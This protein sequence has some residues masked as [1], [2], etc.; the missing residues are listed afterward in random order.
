MVNGPHG[1]WFRKIQ[2]YICQQFRTQKVKEVGMLSLKCRKSEIWL[3]VVTGIGNHS[4]WEPSTQCAQ[5]K[6]L[7]IYQYCV[8]GSKPLFCENSY[9]NIWKNA[10]YGYFESFRSRRGPPVKSLLYVYS[11]NCYN[12][13]LVYLK[14]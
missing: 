12:N 2:L 13:S 10:S 8:K 5:C 6:N 7:L 3:I 11:E 14:D 9:P 1:V 4:D